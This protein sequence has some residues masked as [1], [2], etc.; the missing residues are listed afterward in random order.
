M[1]SH[2]DAALN[3]AI[4]AVMADREL[5]SE[6]SRAWAA[7]VIRPALAAARPHHAAEA[8]A[9][10]RERIAQ[11]ARDCGATGRGDEGPDVPFDDLIG[12]YFADQPVTT[13]GDTQ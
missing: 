2:D 6:G 13:Q 11:L 12:R 9:A 8:A 3:A 7:G 5:E 1:T 4:D 10:M